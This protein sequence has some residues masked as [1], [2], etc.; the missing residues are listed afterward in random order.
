MVLHERVSY[1]NLKDDV[2]ALKQLKDARVNNKRVSKFYETHVEK[3]KAMVMD[4]I[5]GCDKMMSNHEF[6]VKRF[7][8]TSH[9]VNLETKI[10][11]LG[12]VYT[13]PTCDCGFWR[14]SFIPCMCTAKALN[15]CGKEILAEQNVHPYY[16]LQLH[17]LW[18]DALKALKRADYDVGAMVISSVG[19]YFLK[20]E[21]LSALT[22]ANL[23][24][25]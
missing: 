3:S 16:L 4:K 24:S 13:I 1:V 10:V 5:Q 22:F 2:R 25:F 8:G 19:E 7:D 20:S 14:S 12:K 11:H 9:V 6:L 23:C 17:P 15:T 18:P 21:P